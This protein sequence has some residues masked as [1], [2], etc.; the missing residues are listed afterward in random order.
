[1]TAIKDANKTILRKLLYLTC[2]L[3]NEI[4]F[5]FHLCVTGMVLHC[6]VAVPLDSLRD[7]NMYA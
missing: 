1:M 7:T 6:S 4:R 2:Y 3:F 5:H